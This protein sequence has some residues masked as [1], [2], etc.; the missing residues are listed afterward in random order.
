[1]KTQTQ[2]PK[3]K[4]L[5]K[6]SSILKT[7]FKKGYSILNMEEKQKKNQ[8]LEQQYRIMGLALHVANLGSIPGTT[9]GCLKSTMN[10][11]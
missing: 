4:H 6:V 11:P 2:K 5:L 1:M 3:K 10:D 8:G 7:L 9:Y